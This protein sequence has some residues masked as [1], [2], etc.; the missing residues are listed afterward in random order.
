MTTR[1]IQTLTLLLV[2]LLY[3]QFVSR[4]SGAKE[5][6]DANGYWRIWYPGSLVLSAL[7]G[8]VLQRRSWLAG[9]I[10][11]FAQLP[12]MWVNTG[13]GGLLMVGATILCILTVPAVA[14]SMIGGR[15]ARS[16]AGGGKA[17]GAV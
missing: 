13:F 3:W 6:W 15:F 11:T 16:R 7:A 17:D 8:F 1:W 14:V 12:V 10:V 4:F 5:P 2:G 9:V